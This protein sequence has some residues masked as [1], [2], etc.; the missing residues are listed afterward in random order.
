MHQSSPGDPLTW[1]MTAIAGGS[2]RCVVSANSA[3]LP[4]IS[5]LKTSRPYCL[6][7]TALAVETRRQI[8]ND[9]FKMYSKVSD[10]FEI[11]IMLLGLSP[12]VVPCQ[13][14]E[15]LSTLVAGGPL[16]SPMF[17]P[18]RLD[19]H[20]L[21]VVWVS[22]YPC[23][24]WSPHVTNV[25]SSEVGLSPT[26]SCLSVS[27]PLWLVVPSDVANVL[28]SEVGLSPTV[29]C[30][31]VSPPLWL[32]VPSCH[33]CSVLRGWT[34]TNCQLS[35]CLSTLVAG[36][37]LMS[38]MFCPQRLDC[39]QLSSLVSCPSASL[40]LWLAVAC[41][42]LRLFGDISMVTSKIESLPPSL[43]GLLADVIDRL[44]TDD[45]TGSMR[46]VY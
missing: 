35:E 24:W 37:P 40:P 42:E 44:V 6:A 10:W 7:L 13:L 1:L 22:L 5:A 43:D 12:A 17:C 38:P 21:S 23:G 19:C 33:Q 2:V 18:R 34:V 32:V 28:S 30:L 26:V 16:M 3:A 14:S 11:K 41:H 45:D 46:K 39:H 36:G 9:Y 29:S 25:L 31:S 8:A 15:C 27:L 20:Q 4:T